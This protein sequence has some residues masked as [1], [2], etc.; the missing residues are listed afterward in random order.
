MRRGHEARL[1][2]VR[3]GAV[4]NRALERQ[5]RPQRDAIAGRVFEAALGAFDLLSIHIGDRLGLYRALSADGPATAGELASRTGIDARYAREW[6]EQQAAT[7]LLV[8]D[9]ATADASARR[10]RL[11]LGVA[12]ALRRE[13]LFDGLA[14][15]GA[16]FGVADGRLANRAAIL[17]L[18]RD[19]RGGGSAGREPLP[20]APRAD[21]T[22]QG[23]R[24]V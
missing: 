19:R 15:E 24:C 23:A 18:E 7:G 22:R 20:H 14:L 10:F 5:P 4:G 9:D 8:V 12:E 13:A 2:S 6:V 21:R 17:V 16:R 11:P 3:R 1:P